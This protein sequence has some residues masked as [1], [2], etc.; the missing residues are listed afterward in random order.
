M[1]V[2]AEMPR[3]EDT[4]AASKPV[5]NVV[6][7]ALAALVYAEAVGC[8]GANQKRAVNGELP[9]YTDEMSPAAEAL[10]AELKRR[11]VLEK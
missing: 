9:A 4:A 3:A 2:D 10:E 6:L 1:I 7:M 8:A 5:E 11:G